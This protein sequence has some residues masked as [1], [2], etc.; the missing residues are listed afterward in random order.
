METDDKTTTAE[1]KN[2]K[3]KATIS[4][5]SILHWRLDLCMKEFKE[6]HI[7]PNDS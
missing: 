1:L 5:T 2:W 3:P 7:L 4:T 6:Y